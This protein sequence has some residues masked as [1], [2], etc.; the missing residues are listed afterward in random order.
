MLK[1]V[2]PLIRLAMSPSQ[3]MAVS[4]A[5]AADRSSMPCL[6]SSSEG[7]GCPKYSP[8]DTSTSS[9]VVEK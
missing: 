8:S 9:P 3:V 5:P 1:A 6:P 4:S 2:V 7:S